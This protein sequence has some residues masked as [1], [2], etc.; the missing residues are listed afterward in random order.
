M[1]DKTRSTA[2]CALLLRDNVPEG[3]AVSLAGINPLFSFASMFREELQAQGLGLP[4]R[5]ETGRERQR[6]D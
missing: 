4:Y 1:A 6:L 5:K 3:H 2:T